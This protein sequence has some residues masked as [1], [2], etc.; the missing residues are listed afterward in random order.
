MVYN[1]L[2]E[3]KPERSLEGSRDSV[4]LAKT[5]MCQELSEQGPRRGKPAG[6]LAGTAAARGGLRTLPREDL[7]RY[8]EFAIGWNEIFD[9]DFPQAS[10][11]DAGAGLGAPSSSSSTAVPFGGSA[12]GAAAPGSRGRRANTSSTGGAN[13]GA[14][15]NA[16][17]KSEVLT[18]KK[19]PPYLR[20]GGG[21]RSAID[22]GMKECL[23]D[24]P[25]T[26]LRK[27]AGVMEGQLDQLRSIVVKENRQ[28]R[29][30]ARQNRRLQRRCKV[31]DNEDLASLEALYLDSAFLVP[32]A[33]PAAAGERPPVSDLERAAS[34][35][36]APKASATKDFFVN[37]GRHK[38]SPRSGMPGDPA[39]A[40][41]VQAA[42]ARGAPSTAAAA[43]A[44][45]QEEPHTA[46]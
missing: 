16:F 42:S 30:E 18:S 26:Q 23:M 39:C 34:R 15:N 36:A 12:G 28:K 14:N 46:R 20:V 4:L 7:V 27:P 33:D 8:D 6:A 5:T 2:L 3:T 44:A 25:M 31:R 40:Q 22:K 21:Q 32:I 43:A 1:D 29:R 19:P 35:G 41:P 24:F 17:W 13:G 38:L 45:L 11:W 37:L 9:E 10:G